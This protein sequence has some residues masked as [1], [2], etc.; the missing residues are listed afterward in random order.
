VRAGLGFRPDPPKGDP[1]WR[2]APMARSFEFPKTRTR[3]VKNSRLYL[4]LAAWFH[5]HRPLR[6]I[7]AIGANYATWTPW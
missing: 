2:R 5:A 6:S 4:R 3:T 7:E 1:L